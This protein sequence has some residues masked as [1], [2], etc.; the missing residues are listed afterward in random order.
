MF[1]GDIAVTWERSQA[2]EF[3]FFTLADSG[4][5]VS[6]SPRRLNEALALIR[7]F[8]LNVWPPLI[9][10]I[11]LSGPILYLIITIPIWLNNREKN[12]IKNFQENFFCTVYLKEMRYGRKNYSKKLRLM[13]SKKQP[14][15][16]LSKCVWFTLT[17][18]LRQSTK[19]PYDSNRVRFFALVLWLAAT[20]VLG[21][22]YLAQLTSQL[23]RPA[24]EQPIS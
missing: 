14:N 22:I 13:K 19:I 1:L 17:L 15:N 5:F 12:Q 3:S 9:L 6:S 10:T 7:P 4:G 2:V 20:Y 11:A 16:I 8:R 18:F 21:D 23:A 24:K